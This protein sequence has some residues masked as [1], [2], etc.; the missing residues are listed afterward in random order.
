MPIGVCAPH[1]RGVSIA[2]RLLSVA[3]FFFR[4]IA[5]IAPKVRVLAFRVLHR[6]R[7]ADGETK[8]CAAKFD[9]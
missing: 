8:S 6:D 1:P 2:P 4:T 5:R 7:R 9:A 3:D